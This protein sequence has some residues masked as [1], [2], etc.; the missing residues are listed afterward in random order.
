[1]GRHV[2]GA[3]VERIVQPHVAIDDLDRL[4]LD[5]P[6]RPR[7][8][9]FARIAFDQRAQVPPAVGEFARDDH[10]SRQADAAD[11]AAGWNN[12]GELYLSTGRYQEA[13][14][15]LR[16]SLAAREK[17]AGPEDAGLGPILGNLG[18]LCRTEGRFQEAEQLY[19]RSLESRQ[20][21]LGPEHPSVAISLNN[22]AELYQL[23]G[24]YREAEAL[25]KQAVEIREKAL[26]PL[27]PDLAASLNNLA[28][29]YTQQARFA[30]A[31]PRIPQDVERDLLVDAG[32]A[33]RR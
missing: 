27:H 5:R 2:R 24:N 8:F 11:V 30:E 10:R 20:K 26:A 1:M 19:R 4:N 25:Y 22:L 14:A 16:R 9:L 33:E 6:L 13:E 32:L 17:A 7:P 21:S 29:L 15:L 31:E 28:D 23:Q 18:L 3:E 12:L